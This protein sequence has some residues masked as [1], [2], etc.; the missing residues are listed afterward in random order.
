MFWGL[1]NF[2]ASVMLWVM[3]ITIVGNTMV[4]LSIFMLDPLPFFAYIF[5]LVWDV[6]MYYWAKSENDR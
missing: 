3:G 4:I 5:V 1:Y 2:V 6:A